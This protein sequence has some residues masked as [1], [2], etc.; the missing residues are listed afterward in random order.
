MRLAALNSPRFGKIARTR[1]NT[2]KNT[3]ILPL[4]FVFP[5]FDLENHPNS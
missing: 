4:R 3:Y 2:A 5:R 1:I